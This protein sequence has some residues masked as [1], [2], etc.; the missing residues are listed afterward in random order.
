LERKVYSI[1]HF[2][3]HHFRDSGQELKQETGAEAGTME[4]SC[5]LAYSPRLAQFP[6]FFISHFIF[7]VW[8]LC[9]CVCC[10]WRSGTLCFKLSAPLPT[11][12][13]YQPSSCDHLLRGGITQSGLGP[14]K[15]MSNWVA[16][17]PLWWSLFL[18]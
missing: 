1:W 17:W 16:H 12:Q 5:F 18:I 6:F 2:T 3:V 15:N 7:L 11:E 9:V 13:S 4:E 8:C 14:G 10:V